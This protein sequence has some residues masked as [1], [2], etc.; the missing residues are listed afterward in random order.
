MKKT[1]ILTFLLFSVFH[2]YSQLDIGQSEKNALIF[3]KGLQ[4]NNPRWVFNEKYVQNDLVEVEVKKYN[5]LYYELKLRTD[6]VEHFIFENGVYSYRKSEY[7]SLSAEF[8]RN[9]FDEYYAASKIGDHYF[10][11]NYQYFNLI[12]NENGRAV[13]Y[14]YKTSLENLPVAIA[15][16]LDRRKDEIENNQ[17]RQEAAAVDFHYMNDYHDIEEF[18]KGYTQEAFPEI[19]KAYLKVQKEY[20]EED[21]LFTDFKAVYKVRLYQREGSW[22]YRAETE[23]VYSN[24]ESYSPRHFSDLSYE[25]KLPKITKKYKGRD[26]A[27]NIEVNLLFDLQLHRGEVELK[28]RKGEIKFISDHQFTQKQKTY[29][30]SQLNDYEKGNY[31]VTYQF[32]TISGVDA[33][34]VIIN[35]L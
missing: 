35:E 23:K 28:K 17:K 5:E 22:L 18:Q 29:I 32:G 16:E 14:F 10:V 8:I 27:L 3:L 20:F 7:P 15:N 34:F 31:K 13:I 1:I 19:I 12:K 30:E 33:N 6:V 9:K 4:G 21:G 26:Q 25:F 24:N 2:T 11:Q